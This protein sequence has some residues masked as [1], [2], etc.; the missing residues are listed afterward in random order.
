MTKACE[1][2]VKKDPCNSIRDIIVCIGLLAPAPASLKNT[3][4]MVSSMISPPH[5]CPIPPLG[6]LTTNIHKLP[7][8]FPSHPSQFPLR[9]IF[10]NSSYRLNSQNSYLFLSYVYV[11]HHI[12][13]FH[14][15][16]QKY[17][18]KLKNLIHF[19]QN[20]TEV[21]MIQGTSFQL[22]S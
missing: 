11:L 4:P 22:K 9:C 15:Q 21:N 1:K 12:S 7:S 14:I 19:H 17:T 20:F 16:Y 6:L 8:A 5:L 18:Q 10:K 3:T 2:R 13:I